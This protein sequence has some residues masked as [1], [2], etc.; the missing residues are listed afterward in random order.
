MDPSG[1]SPWGHSLCGSEKSSASST[2]RAPSGSGTVVGGVVADVSGV[3]GA[4]VVLVAVPPEALDSPPVRLPITTAVPIS[5]TTTLAATGSSHAGRVDR[6]FPTPVVVVASAAATREVFGASVADPG[7][8]DA[9]TVL[10]GSGVEGS[11][12][13]F[14]AVPAAAGSGWAGSGR[15]GSGRATTR[16]TGSG[17]GV[18]GLTVF[19]FGFG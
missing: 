1:C 17:L 18:S 5:A 2:A 13:A 16:L 11:G 10:T 15:A 12:A 3:P 19:G 8:G 7:P 9:A 14:V 4:S 6:P